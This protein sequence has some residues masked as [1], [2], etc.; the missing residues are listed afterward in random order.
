S[1]SSTKKCRGTAR[2]AANTVSFTMPCSRRRLTMRSRERSEFSPRLSVAFQPATDGT[3][4][5]DG[6]PGSPLP[7]LRDAGSGEARPAGPATIIRVLLL[8]A[9]GPLPKLDRPKRM[10]VPEANGEG[11]SG[12]RIWD[13]PIPRY[14]AVD[15]SG[16][17]PA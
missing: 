15:R 12:L 17:G 7:A 5:P 8:A 2:M 10:T 14:G 6:R 13:R 3:A 11:V 16:S 1:P 4:G 9:D